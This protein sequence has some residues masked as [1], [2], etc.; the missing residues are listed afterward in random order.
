[1]KKSFKEQ[2]SNPKKDKIHTVHQ[3]KVIAIKT[4]IIK[5]IYIALVDGE[6]NH[7]HLIDHHLEEKD[8]G[9][10]K[11]VDKGEMIITERDLMT[12]TPV[13]EIKEIIVNHISQM[14]IMASK[15]EAYHLHSHN[16]MYKTSSTTITS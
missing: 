11:E 8:K 16:G 2:K 3:E 12:I 15:S 14:M 13:E 5:K 1:M 4:I 9:K 6:D 7:H 10:E